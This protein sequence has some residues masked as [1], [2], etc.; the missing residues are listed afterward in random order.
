[1]STEIELLYTAT[2][3]LVLPERAGIQQTLVIDANDDDPPMP[4]VDGTLQHSR[5]GNRKYATIHGRWY[6]GSISTPYILGVERPF[7]REFMES[8]AEAE[9]FDLHHPDFYG[10]DSDV[11]VL[12]VYRPLNTGSLTRYELGDEY[13]AS[14]QWRAVA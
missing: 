11:S 8:T 6:Q 2:R 14:F 4:F 13:R 12:R 5:G 7:W 9:E 3:A 1:M 10:W